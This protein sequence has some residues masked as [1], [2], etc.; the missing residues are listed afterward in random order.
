MKK[1]VWIFTVFILMSA[2]LFPKNVPSANYDRTDL[3]YEAKDGNY[4]GVKYLLSAGVYP[5]TRDDKGNTALMF[6]SYNGDL[7]IAKLLIQ[8]NASTKSKN[9]EGR[10]ALNYALSNKVYNIEMI[11]LLIEND[12][13]IDNQSWIKVIQYN[14][15]ELAKLILDY[16]SDDN[17]KNKPSY[18]ES[19]LFLVIENDSTLLVKLLLDYG[20]NPDTALKHAVINNK[21]EIVKILIAN[22]ADVNFVDS[23]DMS[24][25][26]YAIKSRNKNIIKLLENSGAVKKTKFKIVD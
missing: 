9:N 20:A 6:T 17:N 23:K 11:K 19:A 18:Y 5:N 21:I 22:D 16:G 13:P 8:K 25:L 10:T 15:V 12:S 26:Q 2:S 3:I 24:I 4:E 7:D 1:K 14:N